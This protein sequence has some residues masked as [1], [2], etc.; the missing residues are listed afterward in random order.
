MIRTC[1]MLVRTHWTR[2]TAESTSVHVELA[3]IS[4]RDPNSI[5]STHLDPILSDV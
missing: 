5:V 2:V 3:S 4:F 1:I